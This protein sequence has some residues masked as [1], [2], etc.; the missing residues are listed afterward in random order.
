M[1]GD[2]PR[3]VA[4][5]LV[6][7]TGLGTF[8]YFLAHLASNSDPL[9]WLAGGIAGAGAACIH[10]LRSLTAKQAEK[11]GR[12]LA[13]E[14]G[15]TYSTVIRASRESGIPLDPFLNILYDYL[16]HQLTDEQRNRALGYAHDDL[17]VD[18]AK[19]LALSYSERKIAR[20]LFAYRLLFPEE[21]DQSLD[22]V[23]AEFKDYYENPEK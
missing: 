10:A 1:S 23:V 22:R 16:N 17:I 13:R 20:T 15:E 8:S 5:S 19:L 12:E 2:V 21:F 6:Y 9:S 11:V 3:T 14:I 4:T 7:G 18:A